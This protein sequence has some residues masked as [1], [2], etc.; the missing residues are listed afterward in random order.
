M[1]RFW[2]RQKYLEKYAFIHI[3]KCGGTSIEAFLEIPKVH[4]TAAQ[5]ISVIGRDNWEQKFTFALIRHPYSKVVSHFKY[6]KTTNQTEM[7]SRP[8]EINEWVQ[9]AYRD[10][11]PQLHDDS[12]MFAPCFDWVTVDGNVVVQRIIKLE[13]LSL[14]WEQL[15]VDLGVPSSPPPVENRT[16]MTSATGAREILDKESIKIIDDIFASDF[17]IFKYKQEKQF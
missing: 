6:R 15:L 1:K 5:R 12:L 3:N 4:D 8:I 13:E 14:H 9:R 17:E 11:E 2:I 7:G 10:K 16:S